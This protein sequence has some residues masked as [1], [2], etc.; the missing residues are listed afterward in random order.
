MVKVRY[1]ICWDLIVSYTREGRRDEI[2]EASA[3]PLRN[4]RPTDRT[5]CPATRL[6]PLTITAQEKRLEHERQR[7][8]KGDFDFSVPSVEL[9][10]KAFKLGALKMLV[11]YCF[12]VRWRNAE[13][14]SIW[15]PPHGLANFPSLQK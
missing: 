14:L 9:S 12:K 13:R 10:G 1:R 4:D 5:F 3:F 8:R 6:N 2:R 7:P 11:E 15:K